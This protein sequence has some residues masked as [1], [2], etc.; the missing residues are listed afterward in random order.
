MFHKRIILLDTEQSCFAS[1]KSTGTG[2]NQ[3][4]GRKELLEDGLYPKAFL[5]TKYKEGETSCIISKD[6]LKVNAISKIVA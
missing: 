3:G 2:W 6:F 1:Y 4:S 5:Y